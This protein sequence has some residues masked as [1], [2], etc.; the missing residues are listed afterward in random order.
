MKLPTTG[1]AVTQAL[2]R[3]RR[4]DAR[5]Q[6]P[7]NQ[8]MVDQATVGER[9]AD[10]I[11]SG[12]GSWRFIIIQTIIVVLWMTVNV[13][14]FVKHFDPVPFLFLNFLFSIQAAY[15]GPV[16]LLAGNRQS[17][18]DS[19]TLEHTAQEA[20]KTDRQT[21]EILTKIAENTELTVQILTHLEEQRAQLL[22]RLEA[23]GVIT[24]DESGDPAPPPPRRSTKKRS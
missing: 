2:W 5:H 20:D 16:L 10:K 14:E 18:K 23:T 11:A 21:L 3:I 7:V 15:T 8:I 22:R 19:L 12:I 13:V 1:D 17:Q 24:P 9:V 4:G 6:H